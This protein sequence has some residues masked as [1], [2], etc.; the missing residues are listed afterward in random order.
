MDFTNMGEL[1]RRQS[2][3]AKALF[4]L[5]KSPYATQVC[6]ALLGALGVIANLETACSRI[7]L[8]ISGYLYWLHP[9]TRYRILPSTTL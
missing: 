6:L 8:C 5:L 3:G 2:E 9:P 1:V 7:S 4:E